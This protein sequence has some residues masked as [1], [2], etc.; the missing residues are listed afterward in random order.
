MMTKDRKIIRPKPGLPEPAERLGN[1][2]QA[3]KTMG[4]GR[5][6]FYRFKELQDKGGEAAPMEISRSKPAPKNR[7]AGRRSPGRPSHLM[8]RPDDQVRMRRSVPPLGRR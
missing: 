8:D 2:G 5:N 4:S 7:V 3:C 6:G 1:V